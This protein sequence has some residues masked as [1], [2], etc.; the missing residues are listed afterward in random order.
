[1]QVSE[2]AKRLQEKTRYKTI[3]ILMHKTSSSSLLLS[4][5]MKALKHNTLLP[6]KMTMKTETPQHC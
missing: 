1:M 3:Q 2:H 5:F 6:K 4:K